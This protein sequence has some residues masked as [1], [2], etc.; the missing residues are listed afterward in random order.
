[1]SDYKKQVLSHYGIK[2]AAKDG[3]ITKVLL[4]QWNNVHDIEADLKDSLRDYALAATYSG[5]KGERDAKK[6]LDETKKTL[7]YLAGVSKE[8]EK[9][10]KM[11]KAFIAKHGLAEDYI[12]ETQYAFGF[13]G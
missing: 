4:D 13:R 11:E 8:F 3:P 7:R 9:I 2:R 10:L 1:M 12:R 5:A 6:I